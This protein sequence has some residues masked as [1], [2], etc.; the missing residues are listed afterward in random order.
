MGHSCSGHW[1]LWAQ[2]L[3]DILTTHVAAGDGLN[4]EEATYAS[5][6]SAQRAIERATENTPWPPIL[7]PNIPPDRIDFPPE[8]QALLRAVIANFIAELSADE[9]DP[10]SS[11]ASGSP[12]AHAN[13]LGL[14]WMDDAESSPADKKQLRGPPDPIAAGLLGR[15]RNALGSV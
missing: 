12:P 8:D 1:G 7:L 14:V 3:L 6:V 2:E 4:M 11:N 10:G 5:L 13:Q 9:L 15:I